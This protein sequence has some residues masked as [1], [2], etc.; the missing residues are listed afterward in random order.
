MAITKNQVIGLVLGLQSAPLEK[1]VFETPTD[2]TTAYPV[3]QEGWFAFV[4]STSTTWY[5]NTTTNA[6]VDTGQGMGNFIWGQGSGT[7]SNQID[8]QTAL[9]TK[10][11]L[12][13]KLT[14]ISNLI[15]PTADTEP[16]GIDT[17]GNIVQYI[18]S[19]ATEYTAPT[20][21]ND[22]T[23]GYIIGST[24]YDGSTNIGYVCLDAGTGA[25]DWQVIA[26]TPVGSAGGD[27]TGNYP[28]PTVANNAVTN[29]KTAQMV[30]HTWKGNNTGSTANANDNTAGSLTETGSSIFTITGG[31]NALLN[32]VTVKAN[33]T[34]ANIYVGN[35]SNVATGVALTGDVSI[36]NAGATTVGTA[37]P[38][39]LTVAKWDSNI[40]FSANNIT[41]GVRRLSNQNLS[42]DLTLSDSYQ[43]V[44]V[45][46]LAPTQ[47]TLPNGVGLI[48]GFGYFI[49]NQTTSI[50]PIAILD[51]TGTL[52]TNL[53][54]G[55]DLKI[56]WGLDDA[57]WLIDVE[58]NSRTSL[59]NSFSGRTGAVVGVSGDYNISQI[60]IE[61]KD[62]S[63]NYS[64]L[65]SDTFIHV[66]ATAGGVVLTLPNTATSP[67]TTTKTWTITREDA[68]NNSIII[69]TQGSDIILGGTTGT[70]FDIPTTQF[71]AINLYTSYNGKYRLN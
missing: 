63:N 29:A 38:T 40:N 67:L 69:Q 13:T 36:T 50:T 25:A 31:T 6:W 71:S 70:T 4:N 5:W 1:G 34:S 51:S 37:T 12:N 42:F 53:S 30:A 7:L 45:G 3:G 64:I 16:L 14:N 47:F 62:I 54:S 59:V 61:S 11:P 32:S 43:Q 17:S 52:L 41:A 49:S 44:C 22:D 46:S 21:N 55:Q 20:V 26:G 8:L 9:N 68:T 10:Q 15:A 23:E 60:T 58:I 27:L 28:N 18:Q 33:L 66:D 65:N 57:V 35:V 39:A 2:L 48:D 56:T 24:W 19:D